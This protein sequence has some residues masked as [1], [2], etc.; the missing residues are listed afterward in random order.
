MNWHADAYIAAHTALLEAIDAAYNAAISPTSTPAYIEICDNSTTPVVLATLPLLDDS[1]PPSAGSVNGTTGEL[2]F[3][4]GEPDAAAANG[5]DIS[6]AR[7][8]DYAGKIWLNNLECT[9]SGFPSPMTG[10]LVVNS[11]VVVQGAP[12]EGI[13]FTMAGA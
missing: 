3:K 6:F 5:G 8:K 11:M 13:S 9:A 12:F 7:L 10:K 4:F 2:V 1:G